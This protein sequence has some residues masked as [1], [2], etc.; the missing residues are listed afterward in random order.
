MLVPIEPNAAQVAAVVS[1]RFKNAE[2]QIKESATY[3]KLPEHPNIKRCEKRCLLPN[4]CRHPLNRRHVRC[5][6]SRDGFRYVAELFFGPA[7][8]IIG[9]LVVGHVSKINRQTAVWRMIA[10]DRRLPTDGS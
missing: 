7:Y 2:K 10:I 8:R 5:R 9:L 1:Q 6:K 4:G 3:S